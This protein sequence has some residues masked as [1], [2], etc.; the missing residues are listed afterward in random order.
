[1][2]SPNARWPIG[3]VGLYTVL[4]LT[5]GLAIRAGGW[6]PAS[7]LSGGGRLSTRGPGFGEGPG[8]FGRLA[9]IGLGAMALAAAIVAWREGE[10]YWDSAVAY[11]RGKQPFQI[12]VD[13][14][15]ASVSDN[16]DAERERQV[17]AKLRECA[18]S[19]R[20]AIEIYP[21][22]ASA[23]YQ[24]GSVLNIRAN[25]NRSEEGR[26]LREAE[27]A[28]LDLEKL[29][30]LYSELPFN[31]GVIYYRLSFVKRAEL[32]AATGISTAERMRANEEIKRYDDLS[33]AYFEKMKGMSLKDV[34]ILNLGDAYFDAANHDATL[35]ERALE[36]FGEGMRRYPRWSERG[37]HEPG[38]FA[39]KYV[40]TAEMLRRDREK[41]V[42]MFELW[43]VQPA[44]N[45]ELLFPAMR[46][47]LEG[48]HDDL[49]GAMLEEAFRRN[50]VEPAFHEWRMRFARAQGDRATAVVTARRY[51]KLEGPDDA[52]LRAG[53]EAAA[54][55]LEDETSVESGAMNE[56]RA[57]HQAVVEMKRD[58]P[59]KEAARRWLRDHP[60]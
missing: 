42:G 21:N 40:E 48:G 55:W 47:A 34:A 22:N 30:P 24:L 31:L 38:V 59:V 6:K 12:L 25:L 52:V 8:R 5:L 23:Y 26:F 9:A 29:W 57:F 20:Q 43:K 19:F 1:M 18:A 51:A 39:R 36:A 27:K 56:A 16:M 28:Y 13:Q 35:Y 33:L 53:A 15:G 14:H 2:T 7:R 49:M 46:I 4:G 41:A 3:A 32:T 54:E 50:P 44:K 17:D 45:E 58:S 37:A 10:A 60:G 11:N